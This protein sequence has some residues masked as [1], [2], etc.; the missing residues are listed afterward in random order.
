MVIASDG[1]SDSVAGCAMHAARTTDGYVLLLSGRCTMKQSPILQ[2]FAR[3]TLEEEAPHPGVLPHLL[4]AVDE[5]EYM[6]STFLGCVLS[7]Q[8]RFT[9]KGQFGIV[10]SAVTRQRLFA[11]CHLDRVLNLVGEMPP[12]ASEPR[13]LAPQALSAED[14]AQH[15][16]ECHR[17]LADLGGPSAAAFKSIADALQLELEKRSR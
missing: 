10:A 13:P 2:E 14:H 15:V 5:C 16:M 6:D 9:G 1:N 11:A 12:L 17:L 8:K 4:L 3:E 7:L